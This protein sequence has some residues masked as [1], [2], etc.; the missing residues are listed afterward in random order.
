ES[1]DNGR[2]LIR[3][4]TR[5]ALRD[6][7]GLD[8]YGVV[9]EELHLRNA[10]DLKAAQKAAFRKLAQVRAA[11]PGPASRHLRLPLVAD[12]ATSGLPAKEHF[13]FGQERAPR[14]QESIHKLAAAGPGLI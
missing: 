4:V 13:T 7:S 10:A 8:V 3:S 6:A 9:T 12:C 2:E 5:Q 11:R 14:S 1:Q